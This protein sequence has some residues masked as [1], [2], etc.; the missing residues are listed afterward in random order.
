ML[1]AV[2]GLLD[3]FNNP[4]PD[5]RVFPELILPA[6]FLNETVII[7]PNSITNVEYA[8]QYGVV[9][10]FEFDG[11]GEDVLDEGGELSKLDDGEVNFG[12]EGG[13]HFGEEVL[14]PLL[15]VEDHGSGLFEVFGLLLDGGLAGEDGYEVVD[16]FLLLEVVALLIVIYSSIAVSIDLNMGVQIIE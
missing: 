6:N 16:D 3:I 11:M 5:M 8:V 14:D 15:F 13:V 12:V 2:L 10:L 7:V 4:E 9:I 1:V